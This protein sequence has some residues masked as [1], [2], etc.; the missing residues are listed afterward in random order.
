MKYTLGV[1]IIIVSIIWY[2]SN[3]TNNELPQPNLTLDREENLFEITEDDHWKYLTNGLGTP[4]SIDENEVYCLQQNIF[5]EAA[6]EP[7]EGQIAVAMA[8]INRMKSTKYPNTICEVV[9]QAKVDSRGRI[10][11]HKCQFSWYCDGLSDKPKLDNNYVKRSWNNIGKLA[12]HILNFNEDYTHI[13][14]NSTHYHTKEVSPEWG[15]KL[16]RTAEVGNH[17]FYTYK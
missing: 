15:E 6:T 7:V 11:K 17:V 8:A 2:Q 12:R 4:Y 1:L 16:K 5:F 13:V 10:I 9:K 14:E 3:D